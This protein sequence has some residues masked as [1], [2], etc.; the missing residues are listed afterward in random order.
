MVYKNTP[1]Y[2]STLSD[3]VNSN[4][5]TKHANMDYAPKSV[6]DDDAHEVRL[7]RYLRTKKKGPQNLNLMLVIK[8][9]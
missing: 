7:S 5:K 2:I 9:E 4:N 8:S 3:I 1:D 6:M